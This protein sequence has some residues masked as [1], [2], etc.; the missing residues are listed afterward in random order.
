[1]FP[2][3]K[4]I[5][6]SMISKLSSTI[7]E[8]ALYSLDEFFRE[9]VAIGRVSYCF[10]SKNSCLNRNELCLASMGKGGPE[11]V[12]VDPRLSRKARD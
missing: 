1:M 8:T 3:E 7:D 12:R 4:Y 9:E 6:L 10:L 5:N 2:K 11:R